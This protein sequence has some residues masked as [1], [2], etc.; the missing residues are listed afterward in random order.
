MFLVYD[1]ET[2]GLPENYNAPVSDSNNWPRLVQLA[3]QVH[4]KVGALVE[5]HNYIV[6]PEGFTIPFNSA[7]IHG[8]TTERAKQFGI[9]LTDVLEKFESSLAKAKVVAGHNIEFD[10]KI[11][12]A[13]HFRKSFPSALQD[14]KS[15]D[16]KL[17]STDFCQIPGGKGGKFKWPT[18]TELHHKLFNEGF[19]AAHNAAADVEATTR[20]F[21]ELI[22]LGVIPAQKALLNEEGIQ[23]F[24]RE[25]PTSIKAIGLNVQ[26]Y[27]P[28]EVESLNEQRV[29][30]TDIADTDVQ[31]A[32]SIADDY[33]HLHV[34]SQFSVLEATS[35]I[36]S[37]TQKAADLGMKALALTDMGNMFGAFSF[38]ASAQK[39]GIKPIVGY[40]ANIC[41]DHLDRTV[42]DYGRRIPLYAMNKK[43]YENL[44]KL[45]SLAFTDGFYY[46]PRIDRPL[47]QQYKEGLIA[48]TGGLS[49]E[50]PYLILNV[51]DQQAEKAFLWWKEEFGENFHVEINRHRSAAGPL[52]AEEVVNKKLLELCRKYDVRYFAAHET[53][54]IEPEDAKAQDILLCV[55][56][57]A[58]QSDPVGRGR[59]FR[60]GMPNEEFYFK[61]KEQMAELFADLPEAL[62][63]TAEIVDRIESFDLK[64]DVLLPKFDIPKEFEDPLDEEDGGKRGENAYLRHLTYQGAEKRYEEITEEIKERL[65]FEL[66]TIANTGYPGYFLIVQDFTGKAREMGVSVGPGRGSA[67]GSVVAYCIGITNVDPLKYGLLFERFLNPDRV[68]L[69]DIDIDF[70]DEGREKVI[71]YVIDKYGK[72]QVAHIITYGTMAAKSALRDTARVLDIN[73]EEV[74]PIAKLIPD[75]MSLKKLLQSSDKELGEMI[76]NRDQLSNAKE[77]R[78]IV[79]NDERWSTV[80]KTAMKTEG[81][82]RNTGVHACG[83]I[84]TPTQMN[85]LVPV[86]MP[87]GAF[88]MA[89]QFDNNVVEDAGLLKMDFLGLKTLSI[90]N[91][92]IALVKRGHGVDLDR[93][94]F[95]LD[96]KKTM[97]LFSKGQTTGLFQFESLGMQKNLRLLRPD[98]F[99]DIIAMNALYRPG[100]MDYIPSFA[101]RKN[102]EEEIAYDLPEMEEVLAETYGITVYQEQVMML[103]RKLAGFTRGEADKLRKAMGKKIKAQ[104]DIL[105]PKFMEG[106]QKNGHPEDVL[107][108]IWRD[109]EAFAKYA[110]N[111][112]H[113]ACYSVVAWQTAYLKAHYPA[114]YMAAVL[115]HNKSDLKKVTFFIEECR[116][117]G[118]QVLG[119]D[120][121][122]SLKSFSVNN[123]GQIR[124]GLAAVKGVGEGACETIVEERESNGPYSSFFDFLS[125]V[126]SKSSGRQT[127]EAL[128]CAGGFDNLT[129]GKRSIFFHVEEGKSFIEK[130]AK[131]AN[132][133]REE[134]NSSQ[135]SLFGESTEVNLPEPKMPIVDEW[136]RM[137]KLKREKEY[138]NI[139][140]SSHP[141][142]DFKRE[143]K[144]FTNI[145]CANFA[146]MMAPDSTSTFRPGEYQLGGFITSVRHGTSKTGKEY[147]V[148]S[149]EDY[150]GPVEFFL[151][152][153][154]YLKYRHLM[155]TDRIVHMKVMADSWTRKVA[156]KDDQIQKR[157]N[158]QHI[159]LMDDVLDEMVNSISLYLSLTDIR[160]EFVD[161]LVEKLNAHWGNKDGKS[162][163][164]FVHHNNLEMKLR[165]RKAQKLNLNHELMHVLDSAGI[166][167]KLNK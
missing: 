131:Y 153:E 14:L 165:T 115:S 56:D 124:F 103:S 85:T 112:S 166:D 111:K 127:L 34:H 98:K 93:D 88:M 125:R 68:S 13:E 36:A 107:E 9:P 133:L 78:K 137:V 76:N 108:K 52:E 47:L 69:P 104:L 143:M 106:A 134:K 50:I 113:S 3:W 145:S 46:L 2:T 152:G 54:Y 18:L 110:F 73:Y 48:T 31:L 95:P 86:M 41:E 119:P 58:K 11:V 138:L 61:S 60:F 164:I 136:P 10:L 142:D 1:T 77:L 75:N 16:T 35:D 89:T 159:M 17:E 6:K 144:Q 132:Y 22:R 129:Q 94:N 150:S 100:P 7:Q 157:S 151:N 101:A 42:K 96:D 59:G 141:L 82:L 62:K 114:E 28:E 154:Y 25:N 155:E 149:I 120:I 57:S 99:E 105:K 72:D 51:G 80:L 71:Q 19:D 147:G 15:I 162:F 70:D 84:I 66:Q 97:E 55:K 118:L 49:G 74:N 126:D 44:A 140:L 64:R 81:S 102:A 23:A 4:D 29:A 161:S 90:I 83:V 45:S 24:K 8:I 160:E 21:L 130:A 43:G 91:T 117:M 135:A 40:E 79:E 116:R 39:M 163:E 139:Y 87:K 158:V 146:Q 53:H 67:A 30:N 27:S 123:Q 33:V 37:L 121:N 63:G 12:G 65:D 148:M 26:P 167:F 92:A 109:W 20:C 156:D 128:A 122:E 5:V 32:H 38:V